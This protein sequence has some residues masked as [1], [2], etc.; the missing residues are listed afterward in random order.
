[1]IRLVDGVWCVETA[2]TGY[3]LAERGPLV[4][5][6]HYGRRLSPSLEAL[7]ARIAVPSS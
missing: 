3:Y 5:H 2:N 6:L 7:R 4:E 1:M